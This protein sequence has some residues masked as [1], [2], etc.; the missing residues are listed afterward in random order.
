MRTIAD[1]QGR[2]WDV[3][4]GKESYGT[5]VL[6]FALRPGGDIRRAELQALNALEAERELGAMSDA[7]LRE[8][9][10]RAAPWGG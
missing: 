10:G 9:L 8:E 7:E 5:L 3:T 2:D 1:S 6:I 4:V